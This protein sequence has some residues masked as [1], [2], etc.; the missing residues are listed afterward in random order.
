MKNTAHKIVANCENFLLHVTHIFVGY[1]FSIML[2]QYERNGW[3][4]LKNQML[5]LTWAV[6]GNKLT[7]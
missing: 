4:K 2:L 3:E 7:V 6:G 1:N 5:Q